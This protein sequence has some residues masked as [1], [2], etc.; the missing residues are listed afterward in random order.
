MPVLMTSEMPGT[1]Q[2]AYDHLAAVLLP[3]LR[4]T[5]GFIAHTAGPVEGGFRVTEVWAS[6]A[7]HDAWFTA[8]VA[9]A[10]PADAPAPDVTFRPLVNVVIA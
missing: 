3:I 2:E 4:S 5:D 1:T 6:E 7:A 8:H 10:I 9:P